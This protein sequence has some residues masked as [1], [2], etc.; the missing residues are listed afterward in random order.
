MLY[1]MCCT[2]DGIHPTSYIICLPLVF[3]CL[4][5]FMCHQSQMNPYI[6]M[7]I[8]GT[9]L[10]TLVPIGSEISRN[11]EPFR[12]SDFLWEP[13]WEPAGSHAFD[14]GTTGTFKFPIVRNQEPCGTFKF[15]G[16]GTWNHWFQAL[17]NGNHLP[18]PLSAAKIT[19]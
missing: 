3:C 16:F 15:P 10:G 12:A 19:Y 8:F 6:N 1:A 18:L 17:P 7:I 9:G 11:Q 2:Q 14:S 5:H 13:P 4:C